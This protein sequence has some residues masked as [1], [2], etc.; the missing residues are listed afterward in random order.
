MGIFRPAPLSQQEASEIIENK[1]QWILQSCEPK[2][3]WLFGSA[4][5]DGMTVASDVDFALLFEDGDS[6]SR[7]R[8][9]I[10]ERPRPDAWHQDLA[11]FLLGDFCE[12]A[13]VGVLPMLIVQD[14]KRIFPQE[15]L[16]R[17]A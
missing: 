15:S 12:R 11:F 1:L 13:T 5:S 7:C 16:R 10:Y 4:A 3:I 17:P 14:G 9:E 6:L 2:E 8:R